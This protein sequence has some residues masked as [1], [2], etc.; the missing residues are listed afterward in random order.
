M[1]NTEYSHKRLPFETLGIREERDYFIEN[2]SVLTASGLGVI[3]AVDAVQKE[4]KSST[5]Q[6]IIVGLR[7]DIE[8]G[9]PFWKALVR[10][11]LF[12]EYVVAI[13][14]IG[15]ENGRLSH[16]LKFVV[17]TQSKNRMFKSKLKS[18]MMYPVFVLGVTLVIGIGISWLILPRLATVF[19]QLQLDLPFL[20]R[21]LIDF[22]TFL[23]KY[24]T[25]AVPLF[26]VTIALTMFFVFVYSKT[27]FIGQMIMQ[28]LPVIKNIVR[29][30]E[31]SRLGFI[32]GTLLASG[33]TLVEAIRALKDATTFISYKEFYSY[34]ET[35]IEN[36]YTFRLA[37]DEYPSYERLIPSSVGQL[38][39]AGENSGT[40]SDTFM[41]IGRVYEERTDIATK[42]LSVIIEPVLLIIIWAGVVAVAFAV[43]LPVY[44]LTSGLNM[45]AKTNAPVTEGNPIGDIAYTLFD[46]V[47]VYAVADEQTEV[48]QRAQMSVGYDVVEV[49]PSWVR[50]IVKPGVEGWI[51]RSDIRE[52]ST[53]EGE[54]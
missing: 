30:I 44:N 47:P 13:V 36:G 27:R 19:E 41:H 33:L 17:T 40:L 4:M 16:N 10:T 38:I 26:I 24:G 5:M 42:N 7:E 52:S 14:K 48:M 29:Q 11:G 51:K 22:G 20:T 18:A 43:I 21:V 31:V 34:L 50:V 32:M 45:G 9:V 35:Q 15:E 2:L 1:N 12:P 28:R 8:N 54:L 49:T 46:D 39:I 6:R 23:S 25:I 3:Q 53:G 37:F